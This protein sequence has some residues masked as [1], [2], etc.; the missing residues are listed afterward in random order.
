M[1]V[2]VPSGSCVL[3][4]VGVHDEV[5]LWYLEQ[6]RVE[7]SVSARHREVC[8]DSRYVDGSLFRLF[9]T[10]FAPLSTG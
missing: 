7:G 9:A 6:G 5:N 1:T 2:S 8:R 3:D 4:L 10:V